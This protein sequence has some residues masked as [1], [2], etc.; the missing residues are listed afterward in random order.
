MKYSI[1]EAKKRIERAGIRAR[2]LTFVHDEVQYQVKGTREEAEYVGKVQAE[3]IRWAGEQLGVVCPLKGNYV[4]G[5]NWWQ[6]H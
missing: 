3:S 1:V 5:K 4:V 6:T 2:M